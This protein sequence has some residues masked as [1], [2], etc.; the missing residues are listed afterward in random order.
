MLENCNE[1]GIRMVAGLLPV[2]NITSMTAFA[3]L[4]ALSLNDLT[5]KFSKP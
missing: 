2:T 5:E 4:S 1:M 3:V